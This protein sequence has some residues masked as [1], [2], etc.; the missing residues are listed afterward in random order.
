[1]QLLTVDE[2]GD[3]FATTFAGREE[4]YRSTDGGGNWQQVYS[5]LSYGNEP[6]LAA[7]SSGNVYYGD[8][9]SGLFKSTDKG[10][11]W[12]KT[13]LAGGASAVA[14]ISGNRLCVGGQQTVSISNDA[15]KTWSVLQVRTDQGDV[16]S[17]AEDSSGNLIAGFYRFFGYASYGGGIYI[18]SDSGRTW[19]LYG[20][21]SYSILS[22]AVDKAGNIFALATSDNTSNSIYSTVPKSSN[23]TQ[24]VVGVPYGTDIAALQSDHLGEA[25]AVT[26]A[27]IFVYD[28]A[29][30]KWNSIAPPVFSTSV[31]SAVFDPNGNSYVGTD[32]D[33]IFVLRNPSTSW[34]QCGIFDALVTSLVVDQSDSLYAGTEDGIY[35]YHPDAGT[36]TRASNG[37]KHGAVFSI[38]LSTYTQRLYA[39]TSDGLF[40]SNDGGSYWYILNGIWVYD[41]VEFSEDSLFAGS[42]GGILYSIDGGGTWGSLQSVGLPLTSIYCLSYNAPSLYAGTAYDGVFVSTDGGDFWSQTGISSQLMFS[43][44]RALTQAFGRVFAG[45]DTAG[46]FYAD[47][48]EDDWSHIST[49]EAS[50]VSCFLVNEHPNVWMFSGPIF[51]GTTG[52]GVF[53]SKDWGQTWKQV[54]E[55]LTDLNVSALAADSLGYLYAATDSGIFKSINSVDAISKANLPP[56]SFS[57]NQNY[58]N[59]FNPSTSISYEISTVSHVTLKVYDMLGREVQTLVNEKQSSGKYTVMFEGSKLSS[60]VYIYRLQ[61]GGF[62]ETKKMAL[63]K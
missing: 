39:P 23:W 14:S 40:F 59:P 60:G 32:Q 27:G 9:E 12:F 6:A 20:M 34:V 2:R 31:T 37:L 5:L 38:K 13:S 15:G 19:K 21:S 49:I 11:S 62:T 47:Y 56:Q 54:N 43:N 63:I 58:P 7:D 22:I 3:I 10:T 16:S 51:A 33:G 35:K 53:E 55:G 61:A 30:S 42:T 36:W 26:D 52:G 44:V 17:L 8:I 46:A 50:G 45:T 28:D 24:D 25:V 48:G 57:L 1:M 18:S 41:I 29:A 4:I